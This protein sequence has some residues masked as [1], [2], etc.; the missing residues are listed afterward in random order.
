MR[1]QQ[2]IEVGIRERVSDVPELNFGYIGNFE[3]W[4]DDRKLF[5]WVPGIPCRLGQN[6]AHIWSAEAKTL[7][8]RAAMLATAAI[9]AFKL[10]LQLARTSPC[11]TAQSQTP[12]Q[13]SPAPSLP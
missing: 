5:I 8:A 9:N 13:P 7:D 10:G 3:R 11:P 12:T 1:Y 2:E 6:M 4:G